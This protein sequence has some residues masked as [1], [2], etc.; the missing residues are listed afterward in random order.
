MFTIESDSGTDTPPMRYGRLEGENPEGGVLLY[1]PGLGG[2]VKGALHFLTHLRPLFGMIYGLDLR[3]FGLNSAL[4]VPSP[5]GFLADLD[6]FWQRHDLDACAPVTLCGMSL[7]AIVATHW[8][9]AR[10]GRFSRMVLVSPA[11]KPHRDTFPWHYALRRV[12]GRALTG[13]SHQTT[14]PYTIERLT[15]NPALLQAEEL[16]FTPPTVPTDFLLATRPFA[17]AAWRGLP[18]LAL[19]I[20]MV[21]P[22]ADQVCDPVAMKRAYERIRAPKILHLYPSLKHDALMETEAPQLAADTLAWLQHPELCPP[23]LVCQP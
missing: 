15:R 20:M 19:P 16:L 7:G 22:G 12:L 8:A 5:S 1:V 9:L 17:A 3:G 2:S 6:A 23:P 14:L 13:P 18:T 21:V 10:P 11:F 4:P